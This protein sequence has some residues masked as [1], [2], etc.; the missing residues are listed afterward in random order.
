MKHFI[1]LLRLLLQIFADANLLCTCSMHHMFITTVIL[2]LCD[3]IVLIFFMHTILKPH[4][5]IEKGTII[6]KFHQ[7]V[8]K[9]TLILAFFR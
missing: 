6:Y 2:H 4:R 7:L 5:Q 9:I 3:K 8:I 1:M